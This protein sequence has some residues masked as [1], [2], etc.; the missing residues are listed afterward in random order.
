MFFTQ[1]KMLYYFQKLQMDISLLPIAATSEKV[2]RKE[3]DLNITIAPWSIAYS[4]AI[5]GRYTSFRSRCMY[6]MKML[7]VAGS[8]TKQEDGNITSLEVCSR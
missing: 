3:N 7:K 2:I 8:I 5:S 6:I 4:I 1:C